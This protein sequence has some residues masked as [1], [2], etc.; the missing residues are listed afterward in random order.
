MPA[1][2]F[3]FFFFFVFFFSSFFSFSLSLSYSQS[4]S[5]NLS[6]EDAESWYDSTP[7]SFF[8]LLASSS[9]AI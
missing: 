8:D 1:L 3:F 5:V 7:K 2:T 4:C 6:R 9:S